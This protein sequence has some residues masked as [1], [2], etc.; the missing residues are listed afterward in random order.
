MIT[1]PKTE[2]RQTSGWLLGVVYLSVAAEIAT[3]PTYTYYLRGTA[4]ASVALSLQNLRESHALYTLLTTNTHRTSVVILSL[5]PSLNT[6]KK[7][8]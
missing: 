7:N 2:Y 5:A 1:L 8:L 6:W 4:L 3:S